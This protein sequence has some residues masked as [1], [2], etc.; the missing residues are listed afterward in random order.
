VRDAGDNTNHR[1]A[2][3]AMWHEQTCLSHWALPAAQ[4][5]LSVQLP[6][7]PQPF[8]VGLQKLLLGADDAARPHPAKI[9]DRFVGTETEV[10]HA[11]H[12]DESACAAQTSLAVHSHDARLALGDAE[13]TLG[14]RL[15]RWR[16]VWKRQLIVLRR[17]ESSPSLSRQAQ[18]SH[19]RRTVSIKPKIRLE[20]ED[21]EEERPCYL[22]ASTSELVPVVQLL[23]GPHHSFH[24]QTLE[25]LGIVSR[26]RRPAV[27]RRA[28]T[29]TPTNHPARVLRRRAP[30]PLAGARESRATAPQCAGCS[31][32]DMAQPG[33]RT[34]GQ[35]PTCESNKFARHHD[36]Q[37]SVLN[38]LV[39]LVL[40]VVECGEVKP[41]QRHRLLNALQSVEH[42][43][44]KVARPVRWVSKWQKRRA[45]PLIGFKGGVTAVVRN[46]P[47]SAYTARCMPGRKKAANAR[48]LRRLFLPYDHVGSDQHGGVGDE[49]SVARS[50]DKVNPLSGQGWVTELGAEQLAESVRA[51]H[52]QR[53]EVEGEGL[54]HERGIHLR[55]T[56]SS[57]HPPH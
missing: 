24:T 38:R 13:E 52:V 43:H 36:G 17:G 20:S 16:A 57:R 23:V 54:V 9:P 12:Q 55:G 46:T 49:S 42:R 6:H 19:R 45:V 56:T 8:F 34:A 39:K 35:D 18:E 30:K 33:P 27:V 53:A 1:K 7:P 50:A 40:W 26:R 51:A 44:V 31:A 4:G 21:L 2:G 22:D 5:C 14:L 3:P 47:P 41:P 15:W 37:V 48:V 10:L 11:P 25:V 29:T 32:G 28:Y